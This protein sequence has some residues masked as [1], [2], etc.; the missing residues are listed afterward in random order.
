MC[1]D[2]VLRRIRQRDHFWGRRRRTHHVGSERNRFGKRERP[3]RYRIALYCGSEYIEIDRTP[4]GGLIVGRPGIESRHASEVV[5][6]DSDVM[7]SVGGVLRTVLLVCELVVDRV[8][9]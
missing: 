5:V 1:G 2:L 7:K 3:G 4:S 9:A 8:H 6:P